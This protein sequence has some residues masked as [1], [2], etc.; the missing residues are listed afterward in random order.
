MPENRTSSPSDF[1]IYLQ[2][3]EPEMRERAGAWQASIGLQAVDG[4]QPSA[5]LYQAAR[6]HIEG[7]ISIDEVRE[8]VDSYYLSKEGRAQANAATEQADK[9]SANITRLLGEQTF[10]FS[11]VGFM[12]IHRRIFEDVFPFAGKLREH[13]ITKKEWV[14]GGDTVFYTSASELEATLEYD[15]SQEKRF[16][17]SSL[18]LDEVIEHIAKFIAGLWQI[19]P[20]AEGNTR[21]TAVF[22]IKYLRSMGFDIGN[23]MF[24]LHSW[25]FRNA[26]V[27]ANY[28]NMRHRVEPDLTPLVHF[29]RNVLLGEQ[30]PLRNRDLRVGAGYPAHDEDVMEIHEPSGDEILFAEYTQEANKHQ[31]RKEGCEHVAYSLKSKEQQKKIN[32][33]EQVSSVP[34][35]PAALHNRQKRLLRTLGSR[36]LSVPELLHALRLSTRQSFMRVWMTPAME[37]GLV[38]A[39]HPDAPRHP[40]QKYLLT[41]KGQSFLKQLIRK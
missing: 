38:K 4:L 41:R 31:L 37:M 24:A 1:D 6:R 21:T 27:R 35:S 10:T 40:Q 13:N 15:L 39:L 22:V 14:L 3:A 33:T 18:S 30:H 16:N 23:E 12:S 28:R 9:V 11:P 7:D 25:F 5:Y 8:L 36:I 32:K 19:H 26:L 20:F 34:D 17:F 2:Q 29:L